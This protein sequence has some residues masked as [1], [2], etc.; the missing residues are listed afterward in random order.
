MWPAPVERVAALFRAACVDGS[1][2]ELQEE[3]ASVDEASFELGC[4]VDQI[5]EPVVFVAP[6]GLFALALIPGGRHAD[7]AR[8]AAAAG[9]PEVQLA[10]EDEMRVAGFDP[11][12]MTPFA[13]PG[14][15]ATVME[16]MLLRHDKVWVGAGTPQHVALI[17]P[18][19]LQRLTHASAADLTGRR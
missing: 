13:G 2:Q 6:G 17:A 1:V 15:R 14:V 12:A 4:A 9:L 18:G 11:E 7:A 10:T 3:L 19:D 16:Q 8:V 5:V